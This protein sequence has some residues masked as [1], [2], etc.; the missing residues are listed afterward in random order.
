MSKI[1]NAMASP[2]SLRPVRRKSFAL[3]EFKNMKFPEDTPLL[4]TVITR[5]SS[6]FLTAPRGL[7]KSILALHIGYAVAA[8]K[9]LNPWGQGIGGKV[10]YLDGEMKANTLKKRLR[11]IQAGDSHE[12]K[13]QLADENLHIIGR[14][15]FEHV[16]GHI[17]D[18]EDQ[19]FIES[20]LPDDCCL[21]IVDNLSAWTSSAREDGAA[22]APIKRWLIRLRTKGIAVLLIHHTGKTGNAQRG[23]SIHEDLLDYSILLREDKAEKPKNGTSFLLEHTKLRELHEDMP[24]VCRYTFTTDFK[25]NVMTHCYE[26]DPGQAFTAEE[27][28]VIG[29]LKDGWKGKD[30]AAKFPSFNAPKVTRLKQRLPR[31]VQT[32]IEEAQKRKGNPSASQEAGEEPS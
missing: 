9:R 15:A 14:D 18:E 30:I 12:S 19:K 20:M 31:D 24:E 3:R 7:G 17:D 16:I 25:T 1:S 23:T 8:G 13:R 26:A 29:L 4:G 2:E 32:A 28:S 22:F 5:G 6:G 11:Q 27:D 10:V 21:L